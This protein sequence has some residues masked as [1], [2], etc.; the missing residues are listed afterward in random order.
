MVFDYGKQQRFGKLLVGDGW[1]DGCRTGMPSC[2]AAH[3]TT[4]KWW[5]YCNAMWAKPEDAVCACTALKAHQDIIGVCTRLQVCIHFSFPFPC[6]FF[7]CLC[8][9]TTTT[10]TIQEK[11]T[12]ES[13][14]PQMSKQQ[15]LIPG[16]GTC[17]FIVPWTWI[18][19]S[20]L[21]PT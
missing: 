12:T 8:T 16:I 18:N 11:G 13:A 5:W 9:I 21:P 19:L 1:M 17:L 6:P 3:L 20:V 4:H 15:L 14:P 2:P 10:T 7:G